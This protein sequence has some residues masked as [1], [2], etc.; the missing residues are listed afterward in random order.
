VKAKYKR[1]VE[2][3]ALFLLHPKEIKSAYDSVIFVPNKKASP[4]HS[5]PM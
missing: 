4:Q 3:T 1:A 5:K 2:K